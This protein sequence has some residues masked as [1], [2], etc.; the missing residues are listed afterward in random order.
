MVLGIG[1]DLELARAIRRPVN[2]M[3]PAVNGLSVPVEDDDGC[4]VLNHSRSPGIPQVN[5]ERN[6]RRCSQRGK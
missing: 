3:R 4:V 6:C 5:N 2:E 1:F